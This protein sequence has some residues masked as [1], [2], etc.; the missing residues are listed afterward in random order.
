M[1][2]VEI[3]KKALAVDALAVGMPSPTPNALIPK[4]ATPIAAPTKFDTALDQILL[5]RFGLSTFRT[6]QRAIINS[7]LA[8]KDALAVMPTGGGKSLC[9]QIPAVFKEGRVLV[10]SPLISLMKDQVR[11]L[12]GLNIPAGAIHSGQEYEEKKQVF[13]EMNDAKNFVL[14]VSPERV[15]SEAFSLWLARNHQTLNLIAI[16]EAHCVSQW[17]PDFREDYHK[18]NLLRQLAPNVPMLALT[19]TAT[20]PVLRDIVRQLTL[21]DPDLHIHGF[22][23]PNLYY[24]VQTCSSEDEKYAWLV[25]SIHQNPEGRILIYCGTRKQT[26]EISQYLSK[27]FDDV[28]YYHAGLSAETRTKVQDAFATRKTRILAA[29]NAFGMG[30]DH[31]DVRLVVHF[32]I[33]ANIESLYQEMGRAGRDGKESTCLVLYSKKDKG[34]HSFFITRSDASKDI[35]SS[36]WRALETL[37]DFVEVQECRQAGILTYFKDPMRMKACGHCDVC[38]AISPRKIQKPTS[39]GSGKLMSFGKKSKSKKSRGGEGGD[40][41]LG[42]QEMLCY[43]TLKAWRK[44]WSEERD[45]PAFVVLSNRSLEAL[46]RAS[47]RNLAELEA[48]YGFG[49]KKVEAFG[50]EVL[51]QLRLFQV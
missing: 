28:K 2:Q 21:R 7:V 25:Q 35:I 48:V 30:I 9:Y 31:P 32:Q 5:S 8:G 42:P 36:R 10:I 34:L 16:D 20:P 11:L 49:A 37:T 6:G 1:S 40:S 23:R 45:I 14:Y 43:E 3:E 29:T 46:V 4:I 44:A 26:K 33:P 41:T 24:Q 12:K 27:I 18:L 17:G 38:A 50:K 22:Y 19:A 39:Q 47:P 51:E 13:Q 15:Q